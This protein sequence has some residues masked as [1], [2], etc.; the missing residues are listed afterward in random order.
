MKKTITLL[1]AM[2]LLFSS[3]PV[4]AGCGDD[5]EGPASTTPTYQYIEK[6]FDYLNTD[7]SPYITLTADQYKGLA[8]ELI[9]YKT[10]ITEEEITEYYEDHLRFLYK[11]AV[12][13][14]KK[15]YLKPVGNTDELVIS[16][17]TKAYGNTELKRLSSDGYSLVLGAKG[18]WD[19]TIE[20]KLVGMIEEK[21]VGLI[22]AV[23]V[24]GEDTL[25]VKDNLVLVNYTVTYQYDK[26]GDGTAETHEYKKGEGEAVDLGITT[27]DIAKYYEKFLGKKRGD[28]VTFEIADKEVVVVEKAQG[29]EEVKA[30]VTLSVSATVS[31]ILTQ[32]VHPITVTL[33]KDFFSEE[34]EAHDT[35]YN[36]NGHEITIYVTI[37]SFVDYE[38]AEENIDF[39]L[40]KGK[41]NYIPKNPDGEPYTEKDYDT[42]YAK[43]KDMENGFE[44]LKA[45]FL[46]S[47]EKYLFE[48][49]EQATIDRNYQ[50]IWNAVLDKVTVKKYPEEAYNYYFQ[51]FFASLREYY[52]Y[53]GAVHKGYIFESF[54][55]ET[56]NSQ[57]G[58]KLK[59]FAE[60]QSYVKKMCEGWVK[61]ELVRY[62]IH[63]AEKI[64]LSDEE[65][66]E[67]YQQM[68][69]DELYY[70]QMNY[71]Y[72]Y[73]Q[74]WFN[75]TEEL[76]EY[77]DK[78]YGEGEFAKSARDTLLFEKVITLIYD[79]A[80]KT[81]K[82][83]ED[84][85]TES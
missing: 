6:K 60:V 84:T 49:N 68:L 40:D 80:E 70:V 63:K 17:Y 58:T 28:T 20:E 62:A 67:G 66:K 13:G 53:V 42:Y 5:E 36:L 14:T 21:L 45:E 83:E 26:D 12:D 72:G 43:F 18:F 54:A 57:Y 44:V 41:C 31:D 30:K 25:S 75:T 64:A 27:G 38:L 61:E 77:Y 39:I 37:E 4:L 55:V 9:G 50:T 52:D 11:D 82:A 48:E 85:K 81:V 1:L 22:P 32:T 23:S 78:T 19:E 2:L 29:V 34:D 71:Y 65:F 8:L 24:E 35:Y 10:E 16:Y 7:L 3:L 69:E 74:L 73:S 51:N 59:T 56:M 15:Q 76:E 47:I 79:T 46:E 33:P